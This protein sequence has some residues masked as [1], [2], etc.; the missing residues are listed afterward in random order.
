MTTVPRDLQRREL[1]RLG[2]GSGLAL[3]LSGRVFAQE[4]ADTARGAKGEGGASHCVVLYMAGGMSQTDTFDPKPGTKNGGPLK[5]IKTAAEGLVF[6]ELLPGLAEQAGRLAVIRSM[7]TREGAHERA[8]YL[9]HTGY[10][11]SGTVR[12]PDL[13]A[14]I[15]QGTHDASFD[16]PAY[17][18]ISGG[19]LGS[20]ELGVKF[21]PFS[22][23]DPTRPVENMS[24]AQ[25]VDGKRWQ[26]RRKL[27]EAIE[28]Q[29]TKQHPG[30][31]TKGHTE[32]YT[33]ADRMMHSARIKAFDLSEESKALRD[34]YGRNRFG[35]G[36][37]M[38]RRLVQAG[39]KVTEVQLGGWDTH[40]DNFTKNRQ[41][42]G[43]LDAGFATLLRDLA[44]Q[45]LLKKTL[46]VLLTEFGRTPTVNADDGR[47]HWAMGWSVA[48]AGGPIRGG[49]A[50]GATNADGSAIAKRPITAQDLHRSVFHALGLDANQTNFTRNG[51]PIRAVDKSGK[52]IPELFG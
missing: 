5:G 42:A 31:E 6:S 34:A 37:L 51:R 19:G 43:M 21:S 14:L 16:L 36:C 22:V 18:S 50:I 8:R 45:G 52:V 4:D 48:L 7:A 38:A 1:L 40:Q 29:F 2:L 44:D 9:L 33:Q 3:A 20:G 46:V 17:V 25:G 39:V 24:Y 32:I 13:G 23:A 49:R 30:D 47:D 10:V 11:P 26:R 15:A 28:K 41:N 27:L 12:H 35:Q